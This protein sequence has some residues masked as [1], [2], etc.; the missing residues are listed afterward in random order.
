MLRV[1]NAIASMLAALVLT[2]SITVTYIAPISIIGG[3]TAITITQSGCGPNDLDRL[4]TVLNQTAHALE[5]AIDTTGRLYEA[6]TYGA[7]GSPGA[8]TARQRVAKVIHDANE[9]LIDATNIAKGL[10]KETFEANKLAVLEKL[11]SAASLLKIGQPTIDLVLQTVATLINQA[12]TIVQLFKASDVR[13]IQRAI[14]ALNDHLRDFG[15]IRE[16]VAV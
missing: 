10:T 9:F 13:H 3:V 1:R 16:A 15:R 4:N 2:F 5:T 14:P 12:V 8:I 11:T 7:K 6:G